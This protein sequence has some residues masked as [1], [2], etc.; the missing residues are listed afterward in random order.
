MT[1]DAAAIAAESITVG[2]LALQG[3]YVEHMAA[4]SR[5]GQVVA[6][7]VRT[8][9]DLDSVDAI[10]LPGGESSAIGRLLEVFGLMEPLRKRIAAGLPAWGTC[11]GMILLAGDI[12]NDERRHLCLMD[13]GVTRNAYGGQLDSF[14]AST[15]IPELGPDPFPL[16]LIRAPSITRMGPGVRVLASLEGK[17]VA[18]MEKAMVATSFHPE[19]TADG[20]FHEWF[21][22]LARS[23]L[24][25]R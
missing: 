20:R 15:I 5:I 7:P 23:Y 13:I 21:A 11:A 8:A 6:V 10:I 19:L 14:D 24:V 12:D 18:C 9:S 16:V 25:P 4:L 17:P 1:A 2:V 22:S 3:G